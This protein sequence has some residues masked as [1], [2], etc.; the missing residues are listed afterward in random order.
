MKSYNCIKSKVDELFPYNIN[1]FNLTITTV[2][3]IIPRLNLNVTN[4]S[5]LEN[6]ICIWYK[7]VFV[8][9]TKLYL[10][11]ILNCICIWYW[12]LFVF[13]TKQHLYLIQNILKSFVDLTSMQF[14][15]FWL[16]HLI[17]ELWIGFKI[18]TV[19]SWK[20]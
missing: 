1:L 5:W 8:F 3:Y 7:I 6:C 17:I 19:I 18:C 12:I 10:Y 14:V 2:N 13:D 16:S 15:L 4:F 9:D 20:L 11:L